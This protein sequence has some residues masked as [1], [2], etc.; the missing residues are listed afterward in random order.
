MAAAGKPGRPPHRPGRQPGAAAAKN[1]PKNH[2]I[3]DADAP[4][5]FEFRRYGS[6]RSVTVVQTPAEETWPGGSLWDC[7]VLMARLVVA[8]ASP[9]SSSS[10]SSSA[11]P[12]MPCLRRLVAPGIWDGTPWKERRVLELGCGVGLT[13]L[14]AAASGAR[15][16]LL[17]DLDVV[18]RGVTGPNV[19]AA[20]GSISRG[21]GG[22]VAAAP[23]RWGSAEDE[24]ATA[25]EL[26]RLARPHLPGGKGGRRRKKKSRPRASG[27]MAPSPASPASN[28]APPPP[29]TREGIPD[30]LLI[31]DV[32]YQHKPGAPSHFDALMSTVLRFTDAH[33]TLMFGTRMRMPASADLLDMFRSH[34]EE[35]VDPPIEAHEV[36]PKA[37]GI[38][39]LGRKHN[40]SIHIMRR[41]ASSL[42]AAMVPSP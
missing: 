14:V 8:A 4:F 11:E 33:T 37:F 32:A 34:F 5:T 2:L 38:E 28:P 21:G 36:D 31:G 6:V 12:P 23:L 16:V 17:T 40:I 41:K 13:G 39:V 26:D 10:S 1:Q 9:S 35:L 19:A 18:V 7:G 27:E 20:A 30:L 22:A 3:T 25:R 29:G 24:E 42:A 15:A